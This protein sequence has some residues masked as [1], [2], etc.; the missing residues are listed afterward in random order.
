MVNKVSQYCLKNL[1]PPTRYLGKFLKKPFSYGSLT[2]SGLSLTRR[3]LGHLSGSW[4]EFPFELVT[5]ATCDCRRFSGN[6]LGA[7]VTV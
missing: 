3:K 7:A 1:T 2:P 5:A 6:K 4:Y